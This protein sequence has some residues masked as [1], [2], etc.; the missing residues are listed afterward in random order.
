MAPLAIA[1]ILVGHLPRT[2]EV[3][4][5]SVAAPGFI[6]FALADRWLAGQVD[7]IVD[8]GLAYGNLDLGKGTRVQVEFVSVNPTGA[9]HVGHGRGAVL[10]SVLASVLSAAGYSVETEYYVND[11]GNQ[12]DAFYRTLYCRYIQALG[13]ECELP[14]DAYQGTYPVE[15]ASE[16]V[17]EEGD[18]FLS[19]PE[20]DAVRELGKIGLRKTISVIQ[21]DLESLGVTFNVWFS[22]R[23]LYES[24]Q[25]EK[26]MALLGEGGH[27]E[28][29]EGARWF[30]STALGEDRDNVLVRSSGAPTYFA[31]D[32]AYHYDKFVERGFDRVINVWGAD[33]QG[34]VSR[35][36]AVIGALGVDPE[37]LAIVI[38]QMVA[39]KDGALSKR[40]GRGVSLR[41]LVEEVGA[42]ACRFVL[43]TRSA[44]SQMEF[45]V[46]LAKTQSADNPVYYVQYA[47]ARI[48]SI[49]RLAQEKG[50]DWAGGDVGLLTTDPE[51]DLIRK[52]LL[53]PEIVEI[54]ARNLEPHHLPHYAQELATAF[55]SFYKQC[56]VV[57]DDEAMTRARMKLV[58]AAQIVLA[59]TLGLMGMTA[60]EEM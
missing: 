11:A 46:E 55:H 37:R 19:L 20:E 48:A 59:R 14:A 7:T 35:M 9:M 2:E 18:A 45:D 26:A 13:R 38:T 57:S 28:E 51:L 33:H 50:I 4:R 43:L 3:E 34:H 24:G 15:L 17:S 25:Y 41:D 22:E 54:A 47:H 6:N 56:R 1:E 21:S 27:I 23:A 10:G 58:N 53:L 44:D 5:V 12:M 52:M 8:A 40:A 32:V 31:S 36:K 42:D 39:L 30:V 49:Q 29:R 60:P 16:V